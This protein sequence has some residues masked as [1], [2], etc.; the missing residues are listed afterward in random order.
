M[1]GH[2]L[3]TTLLLI[4]V[5]AWHAFIGIPGGMIALLAIRLA[6]LEAEVVELRA[7]GGSVLPGASVFKL[8]DTFGFPIDLTADILRGHAMTLDQPGFDAS[9]QTQR[10]R[11]RAAWKGSGDAAIAEV[12]GRIAADLETRFRGYE[13][14]ELSSRVARA[15]SLRICRS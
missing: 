9:M 1:C 10:S 2:A 7:R 15:I 14:L 4:L 8:Y 12:Y 5:N 13:T 11:A 6:L 3:Y